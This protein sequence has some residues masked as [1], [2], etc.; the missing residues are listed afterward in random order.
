MKRL[1]TAAMFAAV[2]TIAFAQTPGPQVLTQSGA[3][4]GAEDQGIVSFKDIP[5][6]APPTGAR[7]WMPPASPASWNG[8]RDATKLGPICPQPTRPEMAFMNGNLP[9]SE[10]CLSLNIWAPKGAHH[11]PVMVWIHGG[12]F[13]FG[14]G[15]TPVYD[16]THF[17]RDG[18]VLVTLNYRLGLLGYFA[19]PALTK[20]A[21]PGAPLADYGEMDQITALKWVQANIANFGGDP[22]NVTVFGESAGGASVLYILASP[23]A[24]GLFAKAIVES[25]GGWYEPGTLA[26]AETE[27]TDF[28]KQWGLAGANATVDQLRGVPA[29]KTLNFPGSLGFGPIADGRLVPESPTRAFADGSATTV[30]LI[31]GSNSFEAS[32]MQAFSMPDS[33][34]LSQTNDAVRKAYQSDATS[35]DALAHALF[36]DSIMGGPARWVAG[37]MSARAPAYL[38]HFSYVPAARRDSTPGAGHGSEITFVFATGA[39]LAA[40]FG[41]HVTDQDLA[42]EHLVHS[43]WVGFAKT[44][45][46]NCD[47]QDW[48]AFSPTRD[49]TIEFGVK[50]GVVTDFRKTQYDALEKRLMPGAQAQ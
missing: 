39:D 21:G 4:T 15:E 35:D 13:R 1:L 2:S 46:P 5:Y 32:L 10:D 34:M 31:I 33:A 36:T 18:V 29:D 47:G 23:S 43:C 28:A 50:T 25:G 42:M 27:G 22:A 3:V 44:G 26:Q 9:Q 40:R 17:A 45:A 6:A 11:A 24:R 48:P 37:K 49:D 14:T 41:M 7:R 8:S 20:E 12:A 38:Y 19:H 30:P 16:G